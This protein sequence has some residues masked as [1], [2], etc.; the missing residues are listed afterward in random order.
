VAVLAIGQHTACCVAWRC[1]PTA[2]RRLS[3]PGTTGLAEVVGF[4][5]WRAIQQFVRPTMLNAARWA[6]LV[7]AGSAAV[8]ELEA[9]RVFVAPA[10][11]VVQGVASYL[12]AS[13]AAAQDQ[14]LAQLLGRA[15]RGATTMLATCTLLAVGAALA[16]P[17][18]GPAVTGDSFALSVTAVLGWGVY[19]A[20]CAAVQPYGSLA[21]VRGAPAKV[22]LLRVLDSS[23]ALAVTA[24]AVLVWGMP[25]VWVPW[26]LAGG[27]FIGGYLC[28]RL[29]LVPRVSQPIAPIRSEFRSSVVAP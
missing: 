14:P 8:G 3:R 25:F 27:S 23:A 13:Y 5:G 4:G 19:A 15:D 12:F 29:L 16:V 26:V 28:R 9:A 17:W 22:L 1:L 18:L 2:E 10:M 24:L 21:A 20:S 11:L 7:A 6:V